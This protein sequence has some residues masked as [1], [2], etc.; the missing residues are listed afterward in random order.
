MHSGVP[1]LVAREL[2]LKTIFPEWAARFDTVGVCVVGG[3]DG[4]LWVL[5]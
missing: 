1:L 2:R 4:G 5:A 3:D